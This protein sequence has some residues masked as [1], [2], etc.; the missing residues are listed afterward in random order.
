MEQKE[1]QSQQKQEAYKDKPTDYMNPQVR[2]VFES[3]YRKERMLESK[4]DNEKQCYMCKGVSA[5][6]F[7]GGALFHA[8]RVQQLWKFYPF[9]EKVFNLGA[10]FL[11]VGI[12]GL[13]MKAGY[14]IYMGKNMM[15]VEARPSLYDRLTGNVQLSPQQRQD[16]LEKLIKIEEEKEQMEKL[17]KKMLEEQ[18]QPTGYVPRR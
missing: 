13:N 1:I 18:Q 2:E 7:T 8:Y 3:Q 12:A 11:L 10:F 9:R 16:Y 17:H 6:M 15:I 4:L 14:E 5:L